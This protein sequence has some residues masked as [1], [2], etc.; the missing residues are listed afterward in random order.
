MQEENPG[1]PFEK[2]QSLE[3]IAVIAEQ[4]S[5]WDVADSSVDKLGDDTD[6]FWMQLSDDVLQLQIP[7]EPGGHDVTQDVTMRIERDRL[8]RWQCIERKAPVYRDGQM[9]L[10]PFEQEGKRYNTRGKA[11]EC[12]DRYVRRKYPDALPLISKGM[13]WQDRAATKGQLKYL[14]RLDVHIPDGEDLDRGK[15]SRLINAAK[16]QK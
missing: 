6:L 14:R 8:G 7:H 4:V 3:E 12:M 16:A 10:K 5:V 9:I 2:A 1:K 13:N 11:L 15:A